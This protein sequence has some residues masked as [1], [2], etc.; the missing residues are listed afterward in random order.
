MA[1]SFLY[2]RLRDLVRSG[3]VERT[4]DDQYVLSELGTALGLAL[5]PLD[6]WAEMWAASLPEVPR[7]VQVFSTKPKHENA[8]NL[9]FIGSVRSSGATAIGR[10]RWYREGA[11]N[12]VADRPPT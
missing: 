3:L 1:S 11:P 8:P 4:D 9:S 10:R 7:Y 12:A 5:K 2:D 6:S